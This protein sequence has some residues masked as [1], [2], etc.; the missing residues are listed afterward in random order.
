MIIN[1]LLECLLKTLSYNKIEFRSFYVHSLKFIVSLKSL[2][3]III[4]FM[5]IKTLLNSYRF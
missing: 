3:I 2:R 4:Q 1:N 5:I